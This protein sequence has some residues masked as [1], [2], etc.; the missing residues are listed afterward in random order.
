L[1]STVSSP[2][3]FSSDISCSL[4][5]LA[6]SS[7]AFFIIFDF[8]GVSLEGVFSRVDSFSSSTSSSADS[9]SFSL[10]TFQI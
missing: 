4:A 9:E 2:S 1:G 5:S 3:S 7:F 10:N 6:F 8:A